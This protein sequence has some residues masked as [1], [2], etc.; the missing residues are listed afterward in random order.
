MA[1]IV[2]PYKPRELQ[3]FLHKQIDKSR[4]NVLV[5][6][7]RAG[8]TVMTINHILR[9]ALTNPLPN[10]RYAFLSPTFKQ[11]KATAWDYIKQYAEKIPGTKFNESELRCDLPNG[12]RI[13]ILGAEN[14][15]SLRGIFLDGC[16]FDETQSIK[17][18]IFPEVIRPA[19]ADR[20]GWCVFIG[21]PK[22]R[23]YFYELY[24]QAKEN[25]DW[26]ACVFKASETK[27]LDDDELKAAK[28]VMS[29]DLYD[30]EFE[31]SF[32]AAITGSYYGQIIE[33]LAKDGRIGEVPYDDNLDV[34]TWWDLGMND[35][36]SIWF[37]QRYK[38]E[39]RLIDYYENSG[40]GLDHYA[41]VIDQ[42][43][44]EYSKH[45]APFDINVRELGNLGKSRL[46]KTS[47]N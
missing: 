37:V 2:I 38:G 35:Q 17:P 30:Q 28:D 41:G 25:K 33:G 6:H 40:Y 34:E 36:T 42:K 32:Q 29:K 4:F 14:D 39:I 8:K 24:Q 18:T 27:I 9:A 23:N 5:L 10:P 31:C 7:R 13:T 44:F 20:K 26:Y 19:L 1:N 43:G 11:G 47:S 3:K 22:G 16:I 45:I 46:E 15:Q 21:T 12:A